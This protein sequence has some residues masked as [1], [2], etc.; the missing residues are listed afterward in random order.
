MNPFTLLASGK[1]KL[2][3]RPSGVNR[4]TG[5]AQQIRYVGCQVFRA[6]QD[7]GPVGNKRATAPHRTPTIPNELAS[8]QTALER[9]PTH[10]NDPQ[11]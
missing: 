10:S 9:A 1:T 2:S 5:Y 6:R 7:G 4:R 8:P 11:A 3:T